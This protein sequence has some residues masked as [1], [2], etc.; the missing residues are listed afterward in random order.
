MA[1]YKHQKQNAKEIKR[2]IQKFI[3]YFLVLAG[4]S[5]S[6]VYLFLSS[7]NH[8]RK[9]IEKDVIAYK[10]TLNKQQMLYT[11]LDTIYYHMSL[12]NT[13]KVRN[14]VFLGDYISKNL[15]DF[16][17]IIGKDSVTEFKHYWQL[18]DKVDSLLALKN[19][20]VSITAKE[21][22]ILRDLNECI[23]KITKIEQELSKDPSRGFQ[24]R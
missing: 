22:H 24:S 21:Q 12:L 13:N 9:S 11:K 8:Q 2:E 5:F 14:S 1:S 20:I 18:I 4:L 19:E 7:Y 16:R 3:G 17:K 15:Q 23:E 6:V 10:E